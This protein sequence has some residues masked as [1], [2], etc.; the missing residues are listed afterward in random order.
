MKKFLSAIL[1]FA[2][3]VVS[4][5]GY[6][7]D[8]R[9]KTHLESTASHL[10]G[11]AVEIDSLQ[12][13]ILGGTGSITKLTVENP[14]G[15]RDKY[16]FEMDEIHFDVNLSQLFTRPLP[17]NNL[18]FESPVVNLEFKQDFKSNLQDII[19]VSKKQ[20]EKGH[21]EYGKKPAKKSE[22]KPE[23]DDDNTE[24][25]DEDK[26]PRYVEEDYFRLTIDQLLI[27]DVNLNAQRGIDQWSDSI[28][29]I[30]LENIG[31]KKGIGTRELGIKIVHE[32]SNET[33]KRAAARKI[34]DLVE[35]K[36]KELGQE[37]LD[38]LLED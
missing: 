3:V 11:V 8:T 34:T 15:Y 31:G 24:E 4:W 27:R 26:K 18:V 35:E 2:I 19:D 29:E 17:I 10:T 16:A 9:I 12:I 37:L 13:S 33:L 14:D 28:D 32:L 20:I 1:I 7:L 22:K 23:N 30:K 36:V 25:P 5:Y 21:K 38:A 6:T